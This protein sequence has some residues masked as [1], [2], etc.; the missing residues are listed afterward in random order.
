MAESGPARKAA[1]RRLMSDYRELKKNPLP[2]VECAPTD[3]MFVWHANIR[4]NKG[5]HFYGLNFHFTMKFSEDYPR[6]APKV[7]N[8]TKIPHPNVFSGGRGFD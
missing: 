4:P 7:I 2:G 3:D 8:T 5:C 1:T 6:K